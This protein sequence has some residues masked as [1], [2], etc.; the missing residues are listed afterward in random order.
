MK[1]ISNLYYTHIFTKLI[2]QIPI[3]K[4]EII[5]KSTPAQ[6]LVRQDSFET[7]QT[8]STDRISS[9]LSS[10][11]YTESSLASSSSSSTSLS[12]SG[13]SSLGS[14]HS[15]IGE[16]SFDDID[17]VLEE[18]TAV[19]DTAA[20]ASLSDSMMRRCV[21]SSDSVTVGQPAIPEVN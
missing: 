13:D 15:S 10:S 19:D 2:I 9:K 14:S 8:S 12:A 18:E 11:L 17:T 16:Y 4:N 21:L 5:K 6:P 1:I 7:A 20:A 3:D